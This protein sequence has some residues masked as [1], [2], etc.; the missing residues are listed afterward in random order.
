VVAATTLALN[1]CAISDPNAVGLSRT[2]RS[3][4]TSRTTADRAAGKRLTA[5]Q[6]NRQDDALPGSPRTVREGA[7]SRLMLPAL[8][9]VADGVKIAI[10][11]LASNDRVTVLQVSRGCRSRARA[12]DVY[13]RE[14]A[15]YGDSGQRYEVRVRP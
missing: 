3:G 7:R 15:R 12:L 8:P 13:R 2:L 1:D 9:I 11:G 4:R 14:P 6:I 10:T 5:E